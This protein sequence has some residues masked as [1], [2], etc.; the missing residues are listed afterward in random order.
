MSR[1]G[2]QNQGKLCVSS[3]EH[4]LHEPF[5]LWFL[6]STFNDFFFSALPVANLIIIVVVVVVF[7]EQLLAVFCFVCLSPPLFFFPSSSSFLF[8]SLSR[9]RHV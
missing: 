3:A 5:A 7:L 4:L 9:P 6:S 8:V 2:C 1:R